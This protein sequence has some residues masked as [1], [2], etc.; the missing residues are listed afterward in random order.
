MTIKI[1]NLRTSYMIKKKIEKLVI[2]QRIIKIKR[3][4]KTVVQYML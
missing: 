3:T 4:P 1:I 2:Y